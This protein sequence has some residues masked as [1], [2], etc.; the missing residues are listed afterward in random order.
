MAVC[1]V[2]MNPVRRVFANQ[3][4][5]N[6]VPFC[7][8]STVASAKQ[9]LSFLGVYSEGFQKNFLLRVFINSRLRGQKYQ[10]PLSRRGPSQSVEYW[11]V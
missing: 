3:A 5:Y 7:D 6:H 9:S 4:T 11:A 10:S 2:T 8:T 1:L